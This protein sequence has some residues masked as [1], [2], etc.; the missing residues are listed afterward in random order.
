[1]LPRPSIVPN[2]FEIKVKRKNILEDSFRLIS[3][4]TNVDHLKKKLWVDFENEHVLDYGGP[5]REWFYL[6]SKEMFNP[7]YGLF[8]YSSAD[9]YTLQ[10]K[11]SSGRCNE[12]HLTYFKFIGRVAGMAIYHGKLLEAFFIRPFYKMMLGKPITLKDM[13]SVDSEYYRSLNYILN[14]DPSSLD[15]YFS[16][17]EKF[18]DVVEQKELKPNGAQ[19]PV[20]NENKLEYIEYVLSKQVLEHCT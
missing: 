7:Y 15:L 18:L 14:T 6:L 8:E 12:L 1:M 4:V 16:I 19:I 10:I 20:T 2:K 11:P 3:N 13:E 5:C 9:K 17:D